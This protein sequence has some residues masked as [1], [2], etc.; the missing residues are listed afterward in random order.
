MNS[1]SSYVPH[2]Y[3]FWI[4]VPLMTKFLVWAQFSFT[5]EWIHLPAAD[6]VGALDLGGA[7]T[8]IA[9][10]PGRTIED[11]STQALFKLYGSNYSI[12]THSYLCYGQNQVLKKLIASLREV[13]VSI[14]TVPWNNLVL[15]I[16]V[17]VLT[18]I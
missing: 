17:A 2:W 6:T 4:H 13:S 8:Q 5:G 11:N 9:F 15:H 3:C 14:S 1:V 10:F 18:V 12:Y 16:T 7:S